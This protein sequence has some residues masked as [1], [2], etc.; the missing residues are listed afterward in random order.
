MKA[1]CKFY[2]TNQLAQF[3]PVYPGRKP[4]SIAEKGKM[5]FKTREKNREKAKQVIR[6][7]KIKCFL[8]K[9]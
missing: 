4:H 2:T 7:E 9:L 6:S 3:K 8:K 5:I 1:L